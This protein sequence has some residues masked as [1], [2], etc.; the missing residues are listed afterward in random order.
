MSASSFSTLT[1]SSNTSCSFLVQISEVTVGTTMIYGLP[2][3][4]ATSQPKVNSSTS[5]F[6]SSGVQKLMFSIEL[7]A[8]GFKWLFAKKAFRS[9]MV[10]VLKYSFSI[11]R[12]SSI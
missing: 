4:W 10:W 2:I 5:A 6:H 12:R 3:C 1:E 11:S 8:K 7:K 9:S